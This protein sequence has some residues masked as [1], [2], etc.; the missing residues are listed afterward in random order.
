MLH[1]GSR[2]IG[3]ITA[4]EYNK[5]ARKQMKHPELDLNFLQIQSEDG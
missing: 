3:K 2:H 4:D 1:S 5:R